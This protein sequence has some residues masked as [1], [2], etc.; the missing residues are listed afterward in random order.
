[1][2][3]GYARVSTADRK[4]DL[5]RDGLLRTGCEHISKEKA[6]GRASTKRPALEATLALLRPEDQFVSA[7]CRWSKPGN[8]V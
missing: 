5:Q 7:R 8:T 3:I 4:L 2:L 1:M 6:S